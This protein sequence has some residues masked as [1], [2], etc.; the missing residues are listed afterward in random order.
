MDQGK[1]S[2]GAVGEPKFPVEFYLLGV[3]NRIVHTL[4]GGRLGKLDRAEQT[5]TGWRLGLI[6]S[7]HRHL[8][9]WTGG[10]VGRRVI[11]LPNLLLT[12]TGRKTGLPR[13]V[14]LPYLP[15]PEG[16]MVIA[17]FAGNPKN[18]AWYENLVAQP[19]VEVQMG[20]RRF[21]ARATP[22]SPEERPALWLQVLAQ[23]PFYADYEK[24]TTRVI[25]I[26]VL[27]EERA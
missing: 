18:P 6:T 27:R 14:P 7:V 9:R 5:P 2:E 25:P 23:A 11:G 4:S 1:T 22:A 15:H 20:R 3:A 17:S 21:R 12:T 10:L 13:T 26:V 8:Y 19:A 24:L 16:V